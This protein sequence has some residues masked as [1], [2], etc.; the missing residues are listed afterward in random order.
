MTW[1]PDLTSVVTKKF[2]QAEDIFSS[3]NQFLTVEFI[4]QADGTD[5]LDTFLHSRFTEWTIAGQKGQTAAF[6]NRQS[7][8]V[9]QR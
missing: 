8:A 4:Q 5:D 2:L 6:G 3:I 1:K 7:N 9:V